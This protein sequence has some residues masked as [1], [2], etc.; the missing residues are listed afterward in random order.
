MW[1][2]FLLKHKKI[3]EKG[4][5]F[6]ALW[7]I[8]LLKH[9][10]IKE[11]GNLFLSVFGVFLEKLHQTN[12]SKISMY[13]IGFLVAFVKGNFGII[14]HIFVEGKLNML[15]ITSN[16]NI[17]IFVIKYLDPRI[18]KLISEPVKVVSYLYAEACAR[19]C[20][21]LPTYKCLGFNYDYASSGRCELVEEVEGS[22]VERHTVRKLTL[23]ANCKQLQLLYYSNLFFSEY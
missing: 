6:H 10:K 12:E 1:N 2:I 3:K 17:I 7:N 21:G 19:D 8:F 9:K 16:N 18:G 11:K 5:L 15:I 13:P 23:I 4:N 22:G 20:L 14:L